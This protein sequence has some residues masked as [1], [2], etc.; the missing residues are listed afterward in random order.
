M[1]RHPLEMPDGDAVD[2][3][4]TGDPAGRRAVIL[5]HGLEGSLASPY[6]RHLLKAVAA[7]GWCGVFLHARGSAAVPNRLQRG[8]HAAHWEDAAEAVAWLRARGATA[9]SAIG[10]SLGANQLLVWLGRGDACSLDRAVAISPPFDLGACA[11]TFEHGF[12]RIYG[13]HLLACMRRSLLAKAHLNGLTKAQL[14]RFATVRA[15]D[16]ALTAPLHG[17][18][19]VEDYYAR[20]SC[21]GHLAGITKP[22]LILHAADDPLVPA[23]TIPK[24]FPTAVTLR[25]SARG[26]HVGSLAGWWPR[27]WLPGEACGFIEEVDN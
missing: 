8:Y 22:T 3:W 27:Q 18:A 11:G 6:A 17:F 12:A 23:A 26:G 4:L 13:D 14:A 1:T 19:G 10:V 7:R 5:M 15:M 16:D 20:A 24:D 21:A 2:L 9:V 25:C